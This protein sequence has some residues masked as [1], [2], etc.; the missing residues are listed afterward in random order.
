[1]S[2]TC[3][4][5]SVRDG[6]IVFFTKIITFLKNYATQDVEPSS[7]C[8]LGRYGTVKDFKWLN[9]ASTTYIVLSNGG[10]LCH[11][12]LGDGLKV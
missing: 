11:G 12:T 10:L 7:S 8:S 6:V 2:L 4:H 9:H 3:L 5:A 1:M